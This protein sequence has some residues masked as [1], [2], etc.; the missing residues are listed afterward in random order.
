MVDAGVLVRMGRGGRKEH[1]GIAFVQN[2]LNIEKG[3][4]KVSLC[5]NTLLVGAR[6]GGGDKLPEPGLWIPL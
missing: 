6:E 1:K 3:A 5:I 2:I 4:G